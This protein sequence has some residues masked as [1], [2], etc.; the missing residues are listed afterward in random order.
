[1]NELTAQP[2]TLPA[3]NSPELESWE[4]DGGAVDMMQP[5]AQEGPWDAS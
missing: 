4:D 2:A 5:E 1:M 3:E